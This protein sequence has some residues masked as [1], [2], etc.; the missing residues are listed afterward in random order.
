MR[1]LYSHH[2]PYPDQLACR[3]LA[4]PKRSW[5][6]IF[7]NRSLGELSRSDVDSQ[8]FAVPHATD[9]NECSLSTTGEVAVSIDRKHTASI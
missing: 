6:P 4:N 2:A 5:G 1:F 7:G 9:V 8:G 3:E